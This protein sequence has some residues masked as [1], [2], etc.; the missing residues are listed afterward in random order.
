MTSL[1]ELRVAGISAGLRLELCIVFAGQRDIQYTTN[2]PVLE[3]KVYDFGVARN[4]RE[5]L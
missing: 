1:P 5:E 3:P 2:G 4:E